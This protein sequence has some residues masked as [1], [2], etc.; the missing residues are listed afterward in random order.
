MFAICDAFV[1]RPEIIMPLYIY[2][3]PEVVTN[4]ENEKITELTLSNLDEV[5]S[6]ANDQHKWAAPGIA[7]AYLSAKHW[8][9]TKK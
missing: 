7:A 9:E 8:F 5:T 2:E 1:L 4:W 6:L 3:K